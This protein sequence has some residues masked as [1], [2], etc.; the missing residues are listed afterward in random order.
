MHA[1]MTS[2]YTPSS[3]CKH[4]ILLFHLVMH[5]QCH[6]FRDLLFFI[7]LYQIFIGRNNRRIIFL[8]FGTGVRWIRVHSFIYIFFYFMRTSLPPPLFLQMNK[9]NCRILS[10]PS[11]KCFARSLLFTTFLRY[12][13]QRMNKMNE[14]DI[15]RTEFNFRLLLVRVMKV[16]TLIKI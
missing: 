8:S 13:G 12:F 1:A 6:L 3:N 15:K 2:L 9:R 4:F 5:K 10:E 14:W 11:C 7:H 16:K